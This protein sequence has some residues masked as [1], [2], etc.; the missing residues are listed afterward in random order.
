MLSR[1]LSA[2]LA[3]AA[4]ASISSPQAQVTMPYPNPAC[5]VQILT[6]SG[7]LKCAD[8]AVQLAPGEICDGLLLPTGCVKVDDIIRDLNRRN[9]PYHFFTG[10]PVPAL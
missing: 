10:T 6:P 1:L 4:F 9:R 7:T 5:P 8:E 3:L 2:A